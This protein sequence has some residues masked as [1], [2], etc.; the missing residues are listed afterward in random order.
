MNRDQLAERLK[1]TF[2]GELEDQLRVMN[3][4]LLALEKDP[5]DGERLKSLFR[6]AHT[7][8]GA[9]RAAGVPL[10]EQACHALEGLLAKARDGAIT[11]APP[12]FALLFRA[13]DALADAGARMRGGRELA[14]SPLAGLIPALGAPQAA[15]A[16][17][18][19]GAVTPPVA[20]TVAHEGGDGMVRIQAAKLD[21]LLASS[22]ELL[23]LSTRSA[24]RGA[25][26]Q[27]FRDDVTRHAVDWQRTG[28]RLRLAFERAGAPAA[29][30]LEVR[31]L[32][33]DLHELTRRA[34]HLA[35]EAGAG[36]ADL[37]ELTDDLL[38]RPPQLALGQFVDA[39]DGGQRAVTVEYDQVG[40]W[41]DRGLCFD[42]IV[43]KVPVCPRCS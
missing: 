11:L 42:H 35:A 19:R 10:I 25:A 27:S 43:S 40:N 4:D 7:L 18:S 3:A 39:F 5:A 33:A 6:V 15:G 1:A 8:K 14:G 36:A 22:V 29:A 2:V 21:A 32:E 13:A 30:A 9:G 17:A 31:R 34:T 26:L 41:P 16:A 38:Y 24:S 23:A 37:G 20:A 28:R 12:D